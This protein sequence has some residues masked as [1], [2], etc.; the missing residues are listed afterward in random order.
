VDLSR[1]DFLGG[2]GA[3]A[4]LALPGDAGACVLPKMIEVGWRTP[5]PV[6]MLANLALYE[7][8]APFDGVVHV[9]R[10]N[11]N[12]TGTWYT[13][14]YH[15]WHPT[16][17]RL[18][19]YSTAINATKQIGLQATV[20][21]DRFL[22][23]KAQPGVIDWFDGEGWAKNFAQSKQIAKVALDTGCKGIF[24]DTES[25]SYGTPFQYEPTTL[26]FRTPGKTVEEYQQVVRQRGQ[27]F[28]LALQSVYP[29]I[30]ILLTWGYYIATVNNKYRLL[31][32]FLDGMRDVSNNVLYDGYEHSYGFK[33]L[34]EFTAALAGFPDVRYQPSFGL[35][36]DCYSNTSAYAWDGVHNYFTPAQWQTAL[37]AAL[38]RAQQYVW[39]YSERA[40]WYDETMPQ[41]YLDATLAARMV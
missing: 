9:L 3:M 18:D 5:E 28:M 6:A 26:T 14:G 4:A 22:D 24:F 23:V 16:L 35:W 8:R 17:E 39:V 38:A 31:P 11:N 19:Y 12:R 40:S 37:S 36:L 20:F 10:N 27:E 25:Y 2:L 29:D 32:A 7:S 34:S 1:R 30:T 41:A 15:A 21:T 33:T 13:L